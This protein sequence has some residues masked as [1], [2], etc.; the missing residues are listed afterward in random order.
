MGIGSHTVIPENENHC[1]WMDAG[2]VNY[3]LCDKNFECEVCPFEK[4]M[5]SQHHPFS[6]R[7]ALQSD[8]DVRQSEQPDSSKKLFQSVV[9][10]LM[11]PLRKTLLPEDRL[12]FS[13]HTWMQKLEHHTY[14]IGING[15]LGHLLHPVRSTV[16]VTPHS[17]IEKDSPFAWFIRDNETLTA[18][19]SLPGVAVEVNGELL[20][21]P[22][23]VTSDPYYHGWILTIAAKSEKEEVSHCYTADEYRI[24]LNDDIHKVELLLNSTLN[25]H[26]KDIGTSMFDGG[27]R[28][29][30]IEQ[31]VG[32]KRYTQLLFRLLRPH[33]K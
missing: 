15:F 30:T 4:I 12:Y 14:R 2:L 31:F 33:S 18:Y 5:R 20:S 25:K 21:Q 23:L 32:E 19:S 24:R 1:I 29:E 7:A 8:V 27:I 9:Q 3:K 10:Q 13:N 17:R 6:E 16:M 22:T 11:R 26:R 28:I